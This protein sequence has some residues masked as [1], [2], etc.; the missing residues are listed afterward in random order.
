MRIPDGIII[1]GARKSNALKEGKDMRKHPAEIT[2]FEFLN[3]HLYQVALRGGYQKEFNEVR[4]RLVSL[5]RY[6]NVREFMKE[7]WKHRNL[8]IKTVRELERLW[9]DD[10]D[11]RQSTGAILMLAMWRNAPLAGEDYWYRFFVRLAG[12]NSIDLSEDIAVG[13]GGDELC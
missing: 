9:K 12:E 1:L 6:K 5:K 2:T 7:I 10:Y 4:E 13:Q 11:F 3:D 8:R